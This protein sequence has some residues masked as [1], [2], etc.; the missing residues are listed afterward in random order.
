MSEG[1]GFLIDQGKI[2]FLINNKP[3]DQ[4]QVKK[5]SYRF[6]IKQGGGT[7]LLWLGQ[8]WVRLWIL[9]VSLVVVT[10]SNRMFFVSLYQCN[11]TQ[12]HYATLSHL[13]G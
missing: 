5:H 2:T 8:R 7:R 9:V 12:E 4:C 13:N 6:I 1:K 3:T 10:L 11:M